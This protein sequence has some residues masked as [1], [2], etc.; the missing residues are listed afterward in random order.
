MLSKYGIDTDEELLRILGTPATLEEAYDQAYEERRIARRELKIMGDTPRLPRGLTREQ[1]ETS[2]NKRREELA[3][4]H[5]A[6]GETKGMAE[7]ERRQ[8]ERELA[9]IAQELE[10]LEMILRDADP[11]DLEAR[12]DDLEKQ[13]LAVGKEIQ[14]LKEDY[15]A[16]QRETGKLLARQEQE[17][18]I[19]A[20]AKTFTGHCPV[21]PEVICKTKAV[22]SRI[23]A[24]VADQAGIDTA[25]EVQ[26]VKMNDVVQRLREKEE[27]LNQTNG[28]IA[29]VKNALAQLAEARRKEGD[30]R[31]KRRD[32]EEGLA[33]VGEDKANETERL[34][35]RIAFLQGQIRE[36]SE[37][38]AALEKVERIRA[39]E[40]RAGKLEVLSQAFSPKGIMSELM[41]SASSSLMTLANGLMGG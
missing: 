13:R 34:K 18:K 20:K 32:L 25:I 30:L 11:V 14:S 23:T 36:E 39:L 21:F 12:L 33:A 1:L 17:E 40:V 41:Q 7:G 9:T 26:T 38:L 5:V 27:T 24:V 28:G 29:S 8:I 3:S 19:R 10:R 22:T 4:I 31:E 37:L 35:E 16:L 15:A 6:I 2:I